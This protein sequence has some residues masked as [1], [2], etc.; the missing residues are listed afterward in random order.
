KKNRFNLLNTPDDLY[1]T[2]NQF[3]AEYNQPWLDK[4]IARNDDVILSTE[5]I[6]DNLYRINRE[7][8]LKELTG[9]GKEYNYLL[10]H[11]YKYDSKSSKMIK[12]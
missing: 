7:T 6:E 3:W 12:K 4:V 2:P 9:F 11:G 5:P 1:K 10:E 8:G